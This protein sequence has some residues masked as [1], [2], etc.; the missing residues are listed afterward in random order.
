MAGLLERWVAGRTAHQT[1]GSA[2]VGFGFGVLNGTPGPVIS[3]VKAGLA[4]NPNLTTALAT[5]PDSKPLLSA[6]AKW[7][8]SPPM[9][10]LTGTPSKES[11]LPDIVSPEG[12]AVFR[13]VVSTRV[14]LSAAAKEASGG[15]YS[16]PVGIVF[17]DAEPRTEWGPR[18]YEV[19]PPRAPTEGGFGRRLPGVR[20]EPV[21]SPRFE[22]VPGDRRRTNDA[23]FSFA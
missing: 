23:G 16:R 8:A 2:G 4:T 22:P 19:E 17:R 12:S 7:S 15:G 1:A 18:G 11:G 20:T 3:A 10:S 21:S 14:R 5:S 9:S 13:D 6:V